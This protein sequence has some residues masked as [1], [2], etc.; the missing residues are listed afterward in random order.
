V[1]EGERDVTIMIV[2]NKES[3]EGKK[4]FLGNKELDDI[5]RYVP[6]IRSQFRDLL[7]EGK[8]ILLEWSF[9][10]NTDVNHRPL[11]G[12]YLVFYEIRTI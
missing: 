3:I 5:L 12:K 11:N 7:F 9:A 8:S 10:Y 6:L 2:G 1:S 4:D